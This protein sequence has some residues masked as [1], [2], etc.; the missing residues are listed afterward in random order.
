MRRS[1]VAALTACVVVLLRGCGADAQRGRSILL[2]G[3]FMTCGVPAKLWEKRVDLDST[4]FDEEALGWPYVEVPYSQAEA[5]VS[6][7][8]MVY[9]TTYWSQSNEGH[10][11]GDHLTTSERRAVL[12]FLK[13]I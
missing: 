11:F 10:P 9:D 8:T 6:E 7:R 12:E 3:D 2:A 5:P 4:H 1:L 13:T